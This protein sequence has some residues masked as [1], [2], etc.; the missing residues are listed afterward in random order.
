MLAI[1]A[2]RDRESTMDRREKILHYLRRDGLGLEIGPSFSP[3]APKRDGY[4]VEILDHLTAEELKTKYRGHPGVVVDHIENVDHVWRGERFE[5]LVGGRHR[6]DWIIASH[7]IEHSP[8]LIT[9]V[10]DCASVL[11]PDGVLSLA[12]PDKRYCFD[13]WRDRTG[14]ARVID[15]YSERRTIHSPG[16]AAEYYLNVVAR[17]GAIAWGPEVDPPDAGSLQ[18]MHS[19]GDARA[20]IERIRDCEDYID[21]HSWVFTPHSFRLLVNDLADLGYTRL[22]EKSWY[23]SAGC[24][25]FITLGPNGR[26][27]DLG[28]KELLAASHGER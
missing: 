9:F 17:N 7:V 16:S 2:G 25:F 10:E 14:I 21:M 3:I 13:Y 27:P 26:G 20:A 5:A 4:N 6:Y 22:R 1:F 19:I 18:L 24:E 23:P 8:C 11:K 15:A 28:R 12:V